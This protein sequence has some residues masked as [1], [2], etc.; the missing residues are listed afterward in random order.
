MCATYLKCFTSNCLDLSNDQNPSIAILSNESS[1]GIEPRLVLIDHLNYATHTTAAHGQ[2]CAQFKLEY[3]KQNHYNTKVLHVSGIIFQL[4]SI[5]KK[6]RH[7]YPEF[8]TTRG[9][10]LSHHGKK[11]NV[12]HTHIVSQTTIVNTEKQY[13][14]RAK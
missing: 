8:I 7:V 12:L 14:K 3:L 11:K 6:N 4:L 9:I 13:D 10:Y 1:M 2:N 5:E